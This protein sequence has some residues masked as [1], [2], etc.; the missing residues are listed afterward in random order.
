MMLPCSEDM[1]IAELA[2]QLRREKIFVNSERQLLQNLNEEVEKSSLELLQVAWICSQQRQNLTNLITSR[3]EADSVVACQKIS[4]L[5]STTF[6]DIYKV[7]KYKVI[8]RIT[9]KTY[10]LAGKSLL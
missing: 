5:E 8:V 7:L 3:C 9:L 1:N 6:V 2:N 10:S 4:L